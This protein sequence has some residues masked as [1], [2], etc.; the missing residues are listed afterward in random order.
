E[1]Y[2]PTFAPATVGGGLEQLIEPLRY[3]ETASRGFVVLTVTP[4]ETRAEY[5]YVDTVRSK[6]Y[7]AA[8][9]KT[10]RTLPGAA[11]RKI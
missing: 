6:T 9:R 10:L 11:N 4:T 5:R 1:S 8:T 3:A 2:F 7:A